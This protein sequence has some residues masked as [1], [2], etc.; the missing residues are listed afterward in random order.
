MH[1]SSSARRCGSWRHA[2][3]ALLALVHEEAA[4]QRQHGPQRGLGHRGGHRGV[5]HAR[6]RHVSRQRGVVE[7]AGRR[8]PTTTGSAAAAAGPRRLPGGGLATIATSMRRAVEQLVGRHQMVLRHRL[9]QCGMPAVALGGRRSRR[10]AAGS[11]A[12]SERCSR[13]SQRVPAPLPRAPARGHRRS[14]RGRCRPAACRRGAHREAKPHGAHRL[15]RRCLRPA[16]RC[17]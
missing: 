13:P 15:A 6:E 1:G 17:R 9:R 5:D 4:V 16:R 10:P 12:A 11:C 8:R 2:R 3:L 14:C 7:Q